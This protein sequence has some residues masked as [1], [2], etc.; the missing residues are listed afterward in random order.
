[1]AIEFACPRLRY[2]RSGKLS[3]QKKK[4]GQSGFLRRDPTI[5]QM[6]QKS[7]LNANHLFYF[8]LLSLKA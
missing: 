8:L 3:R 6:I 7:T 4:N 5:R 1:M 2:F